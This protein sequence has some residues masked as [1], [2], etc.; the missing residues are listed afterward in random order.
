MINLRQ[1][2][3]LLIAVVVTD[4]VVQAKTIEELKKAGDVRGLV[5][6]LDDPQGDVRRRAAFAMRQIVTKVKDPANLDPL[7]GRLIEVAFHDLWKSTRGDCSGIL[8]H[9]LKKTEDQAVLRNTL[10]PIFDALPHGQVD[11]SRRHYAATLLYVVGRRLDCVDDLMKPRIPELLTATFNDPNEHVRDY[12]GR[13]LSNVL[14]KIDDEAA[15]SKAAHHFVA[16]RQLKSKDLRARRY[17]AEQLYNLVRK[18]KKHPTLRALQGRIAAATKDRDER[19]RESAGRA[20]RQI[21][22]GLKRKEET[23]PASPTEG[24]VS[25]KPRN[26]LPPVAD[27]SRKRDEPLKRTDNWRDLIA[28]LRDKN[29]EICQRAAAALQNALKQVRREAELKQVI[30]PLL[31]ATLNDS[32]SAVRE[33]ARHALRHVLGKVTDEAVLISVAKL[34][35]AGLSHKDE[36]VRSHCAHD[37]SEVMRKIEDEKVL[38]GLLPSLTNATLK[39]ESMNARDFPGF[40]LRSV[41]RKVNDSKAVTP[42]M[43]TFV[44]ELKHK[45]STMRTFFTHGLHENVGKIKDKAVL[46]R[47]VAPLATAT[48]TLE[49]TDAK[50]DGAKAGEL[51]Y[52]ALRQVLEQV[53]DQAALK[54]IVLP[55]AQALKAK[56]VKRRRYVAHTV[57]LFGYKVK[58]KTAL[59][60]LVRPLVDAHFH[61]SDK[62][63]RES[64]G[65]ALERTFGRV[66]V[67]EAK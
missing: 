6:K 37:L 66:E 24:K 23:K 38:A 19:V 31:H 29:P 35:V 32:R 5:A 49:V 16:N 14:N 63:V 8:E 44:G 9:L 46:V 55:M 20:L 65:R 62:N 17:S 58:D 11:A 41:L 18:I 27:V 28:K 13:A 4:N 61:D 64:A 60:S 12:T 48:V 15:L 54:S 39:S 53:D 36:T 57:M 67:T 52:F 50:T 22:N 25:T 42:V 26:V 2:V 30:P 40:V 47:M 1:G 59:T 7:I 34:Y 3:M 33:P 43:Q 56:E 10:Q 51:A 45:D 21:E